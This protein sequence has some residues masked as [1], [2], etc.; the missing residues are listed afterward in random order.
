MPQRQFVPTRADHVPGNP[1]A[2]LLVALVAFAIAVSL[3]MRAW[4]L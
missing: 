4:I 1:G 2:L 3:A